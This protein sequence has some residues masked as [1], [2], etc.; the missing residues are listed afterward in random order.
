MAIRS[1]KAALSYRARRIVAW[2][3]GCAFE[4]YVLV[5][6]PVTKM[7]AEPGAGLAWG[8]TAP[9][10]A[11]AAGLA[12]AHA[13]AWR[14][15]QGMTCLG[16]WRRDTLIAATWVGEGG[17]DEDEAWLRFELPQGAAWDTGMGVAPSARAGRAFAALW[18]ATREW[19]RGRGLGWSV[20][21]IADYNL[22]S[23]RA[24][25]R[26]GAREIGRV[27]LVRVGKMQLVLGA[28]PILSRVGAGRPV[29]RVRLGG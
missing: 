6:V 18:T 22:P 17:F 7:P 1:W 14:I 29:V 2:V 19:A 4:R 9:E 24:H 23:R 26:L 25:A 16:V 11:V 21:R 20:S 12:D 8:E 28:R 10:L 5:A 27:S 13:A 3:P 15:T